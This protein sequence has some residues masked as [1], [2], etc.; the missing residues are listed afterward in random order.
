MTERIA[1]GNAAGGVGKTTA[2]K[3]LGGA[4]SNAGHDVLLVDLDPQGTLTEGVGLRDIYDK[5]ILS[6][7]QIL[8]DN[9]KIQQIDQIVET[10]DEF[11]VIPANKAMDGLKDILLTQTAN[12]EMRLKLALDE[13][14]TEYDYILIDCPPDL[15]QIL[16]NALL[17]AEQTLM[18]VLP[19]RRSI[20]AIKKMNE[21]IQYLENSFPGQVD[22]IEVLGLIVNQVEDTLN[23]DT[24]EM[25]EF[26]EDAPYPVFQVPDRVAIRRAWNNG[27]SVFE[28]EDPAKLSDAR[29]AY[30]D[31]AEMLENRRVEA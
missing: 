28:H 8:T 3:N 30:S 4:L 25:L 9:G 31:I 21:E 26:F 7:H 18:P 19:T 15:S 2:T 29:Q 20:R 11:D 10:H 16:D 24:K 5:K 14:D 23:N 13:L 27:V 12:S 17:A 22:S 6:L 1:L